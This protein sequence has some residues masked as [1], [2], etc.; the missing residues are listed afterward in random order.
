MK[1]M[2]KINVS[3]S[4]SISEPQ[5]LKKSGI[6][7]A[8][9]VVVDTPSRYYGKG[10]A[11]I[12]PNIA[13]SLEIS[14]GEYLK[15][16]GGMITYARC[17]I[18]SESQNYTDVSS[19]LPPLQI[20]SNVRKNA[21]VVLGDKVQIEKI[22]PIPATRV[23]FAEE[24]NIN[25]EKVLLDE[26]NLNK[27]LIGA[28]IARK[29]EIW[30]PSKKVASLVS[31]TKDSVNLIRS[32]LSAFYSDIYYVAFHISPV[33][34][35]GVYK[36]TKN[37][38]I[39]IRPNPIVSISR[40]GD[41]LDLLENIGG[42][43]K[44]RDQL[45]EFIGLKVLQSD[46]LK[47]SNLKFSNAILL[48]G[49][50]GLGKSILTKAVANQFPVCVYS[51]N[52]PDLIGDK[53]QS[54]P[55]EL[56]KIFKN[57]KKTAPS[58]I[59][60]DEVEALAYNREDLKFDALTRNIVTSFLHLLDSLN[61]SLDVVLIATTNKPKS[62]DMAFRSTNRFSKEIQFKAPSID[63]RVEIISLIINK[64]PFFPNK[65]I[66]VRTVAELCNGFTGADIH[67]L[68][69]EVFIDFLKQSGMYE[70]FISQSMKFENVAPKIRIKTSNFHNVLK[71]KLVK[72]SLLRSYLIETPKQKFSDVGGLEE[73]KL[74][75]EENIRNPIIY[76]EL[77]EKFGGKQTRGILLHGPP[78][79]GKTL[80]GKALASETNMNFI[81]IKGAE[82]LNRWLG[83]S[84]AAI[85]E[86][87]KKARDAAPCIIFFDELDA[88]ST[89]RGVDGNV[90]SDR[91]TAQIL[92][93]LDGLD[94]MKGV[95]CIGATNRV[96]IIDPA[97]MR[98]GRLF[99]VI[100]IDM[101][102]KIEREAIF[103]IHIKSM[104]ISADLKIDALTLMSDGLSGASIE[105][106]CHQASLFAIRENIEILSN[107]END[108]RVPPSQVE[109]RHFEKALKD[110]KKKDEKNGKK[111]AFYS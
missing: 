98:P 10:F 28:A 102:N 27:Y 38:D 49:P 72:P 60:V 23:V 70:R 34:K 53:P 55:A 107:T 93:E 109:F 74:L 39:I 44:E 31:K 89:I 35:N 100:K 41:D 21:D 92:T 11:Y 42:L 91:V 108:D 52:G 14:D 87:F 111:G 13:Q 68:F 46:L 69:Q 6:K 36:I 63:D 61:D 66:D 67:H 73:A 101:P 43:K 20:D 37:T 50:S 1:E 17:K 8:S 2:D 57:A 99:P 104:P 76:P 90:H 81:Y 75:L 40:I 51:I 79:C 106:I 82:V 84:E 9:L 24:E 83:E 85:R 71:A 65:T 59:I 54:A 58:V 64:S 86:I 77:Y 56:E 32:Q 29:N 62:I 48:T 26:K 95:I 96:D 47:Y 25:P 5:N 16:I 78:G 97:V 103:K 18:L 12:P 19:N 15:I 4:N 80:L 45:M 110:L 94:E 33:K 88:V 3:S 22:I 105:K 7:F 30:I